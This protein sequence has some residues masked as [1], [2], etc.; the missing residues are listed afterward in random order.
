MYT[1]LT[2]LSFDVP[3][4]RAVFCFYCGPIPYVYLY[5]AGC[6]LRVCPF[7]APHI[8]PPTPLP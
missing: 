8:L 6:V 7:H 4:F 2:L 1:D 5:L 3:L